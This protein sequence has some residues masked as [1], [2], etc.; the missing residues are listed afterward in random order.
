[1][2]APA[3][4]LIAA[5]L[6]LILAGAIPAYVVQTSVSSVDHQTRPVRWPVLPVDFVLDGGTLAGG[7][8]E[9]LILNALD[10]WD[11]VPTARRVG[12]DL[13]VYTDDQGQPIY[14]PAG[15]AS[16]KRVFT[17]V[18]VTVQSTPVP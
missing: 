16:E 6:C 14:S 12:G 15:A 11:N 9:T 13:Y 3:R 10:A 5:F 1:M 18:G 7:D 8:G 2:N 4:L 17:W